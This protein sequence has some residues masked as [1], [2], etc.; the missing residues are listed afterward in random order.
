MKTSFILISIFIIVLCLLIKNKKQNKIITF[1]NKYHKIIFLII[2]VA[3]LFLYLYKLDIV[4]IGLNTD[5][6]GAAYDAYSL[7]HY[8]VDRFLYKNPVYF[9]NYGSGQNALYTYILSILLRFFDYS[10]FLIRIPAVVFGILSLIFVYKILKENKDTSLAIITIF[11]ML[12]TP[13]FIMKSRWALESYLF[14][15]LLAISLYYFMRAVNT[16]KRKY[17]FFSGLLFG[18]TL[19]TYAISYIVIFVFVV[20]NSLYLLLNKKSSI[21]NLIT[22]GIPLF[23]LALPLIIMLLINSN[24][25]SH[26]I[27]TNLF[28][29]PKLI[30]Y[31]GSELSLKNIKYNL[32][33]NYLYSVIF[34]DDYCT[35]N[36]ISIYGTLYNISILFTILGFVISLINVYKSLKRK[37]YNLDIPLLIIFL[38]MLLLSLCISY[39]NINKINCLYLP[40]V[41]YIGL[42]IKYVFKKSDIFGLIILSLYSFYFVNFTKYYF[43]EYPFYTKDIAHFVSDDFYD[44]LTFAK[45]KSQNK[46]IINIDNRNIIQPY[47]Y[48]LLEEKTNPYTFNKYLKM[49]KDVV[50]SYKKYNFVINEIDNRQIYITKD[51]LE[52]NMKVKNFGM[53]NVYYLDTN[54]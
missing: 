18:I 28:S 26:E 50:L 17:F 53:F 33:N 40:I 24:I 3:S 35:W 19:Y 41:Y 34:I 36:S 48:I 6:A 32:S 12:I 1:I 8:G 15:P 5:E 25:I 14:L 52:T 9:I 39:V 4:P 22:F 10:L 27:K 54:I 44:A 2:I 13:F 16:S 29:I 20:I 11:I 49:K 42:G 47:I 23:L 38:T 43:N 7:A 45:A 30:Y 21:S 37:E 51:Y 46:K 31:R